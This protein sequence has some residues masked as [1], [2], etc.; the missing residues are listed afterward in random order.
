MS[1]SR[2]VQVGDRY[3]LVGLAVGV[4]LAGALV[5]AGASVWLTIA[6]GCAAVNLTAYALRRQAGIPQVT[7]RQRWRHAR[8]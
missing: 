6:L 7:L 8:R 3:D 1:W 4:V 2:P 5:L